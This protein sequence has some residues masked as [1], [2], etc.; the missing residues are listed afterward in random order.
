MRVR[1]DGL[2]RPRYNSEMFLMRYLKVAAVLLWISV[3][4][5]GSGA[6]QQ[7]VWFTKSGYSF[8]DELGG[9]KIT[10]LGG[11]GSAA[12]PI[13]IRQDFL[14]TAPAVLV[15]RNMMLQGVPADLFRGPFLKLAIAIEVTNA[16]QRV[17]AGF[18]LELQEELGQPS[19]HGDG[20]SFDQ[21]K[22]FGDRYFT[23]DRFAVAT[24]SAEPYD[25]VRFHQG[26][27]DPGE[28]VRFHI[29]ILD[30]SPTAEFYL[31]LEPQLLAV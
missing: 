21:L 18:D 1:S 6:A 20:L 12:D 7:P 19:L 15:I 31:V 28:A 4:F 16:S 24:D 9:F 22:A 27:V 23:S 30:V 29:F 14:D 8:S 13:L 17:W 10:G 11:T 25:R 2:V 5:P 26:K 3:A